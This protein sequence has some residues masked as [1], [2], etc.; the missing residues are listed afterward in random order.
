MAA[1][2]IKQDDVVKLRRTPW[3]DNFFRPA[4]IVAMIM[5]LNSAVVQLVWQANPEWNG[6]FFLLG[7]LLTTVEAVYSHRILHRFQG[8]GGSTVRFRLVEILFLL[9]LLKLITLFGKPWPVITTEFRAIIQEPSRIV[10]TEYY[11]IVTLAIAAWAATTFTIADLDSLYDPYTDN[12]VALDSLAERFFWGGGLLVLISGITQWVA[13]S[14]FRSLVNLERPAMGGVVFNVLLYFMLG[15]ILLSQI[16][17]TRLQ[18]R[19]E[20]QKIDV[21]PGMIRRWVGYGLLFLAILTMIALILPTSY[22]MGLLQTAGYL[23]SYLFGVLILLFQMIVVLMTLP[24]VLLLTWL[25]YSSPELMSG[26]SLMPPPVLPDENSTS[27]G[28][29]LL[30]R[31]V[32]FWMVALGAIGYLLKTYLDD[33]PDLVRQLLSLRLIT[34]MVRFLGNFWLFVKNSLAAGLQQFPTL[35]NVSKKEG[36]P[37]PASRSGWFSRHSNS[38]QRRIIRYYLNIIQQAGRKGTQRR[39]WQTPNEFEPE[40]S[41]TAPEAE[42]EIQDLT[43]AFI[44]ARYGP[45][46]ANEA[47]AS[48]VQRW[49]QR[50][51]RVLRRR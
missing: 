10:T 43:K 13:H 6:T 49:W 28:W 40:L 22:G 11:I 31:S 15:F 36:G 51:K 12:R 26:T 19:W 1:R 3:V 42:Q 50:I 34:M 39:Q 48:S 17:L 23:L 9:L 38:P 7:M 45:N 8:Q 4:I 41:H 18:V 33:R 27:P 16:N 35:A 5:C 32:L 20:T 14:G 44:Q 46:E 47:H 25:G 30:I 37:R 2:Q 29:L 24:V 21:A